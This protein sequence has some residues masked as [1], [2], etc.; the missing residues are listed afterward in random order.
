MSEIGKRIKQLRQKA[1]LNQRELADMA[2]V[3]FSTLRRWEVYGASPRVEEISKLAAALH[4]TEAEL[5]NGAENES[6]TLEIKFDNS[7]KELVNM[8]AD[9]PCLSSITG[10]KSGAVLTLSGKWDTFKDDAKFQ[11][12]VDQLIKARDKILRMSEDWC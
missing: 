5:L 9:V 3:S 8:T 12:F 7:Q 6:W 1:G 10:T 11:D 2:G 4:V